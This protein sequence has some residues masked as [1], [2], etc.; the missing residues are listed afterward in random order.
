MKDII[1]LAKERADAF[2][3]RNVVVSTNSGTTAKMVLEVF[4]KRY[5]IIAVGNP[6]SAHERGLVRHKG[7]SEETRR[8]LELMGIRVVLQDQ[9]LF[10]AVSIGG[11][12]YYIGDIDITGP[13]PNCFKAGVSLEDIIK[14]AGPRGPYNPIAIIYNALQIFGDGP[15]VCLEVSLMAADSGV[16]PL[17]ADCISIQRRAGGESNMPDAALVL[18]PTKTQDI[19]NGQLR[20]KDLILVPGPKDHWFDNGPLWVG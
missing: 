1:A 17:D 10:Q 16:L 7:I 8:S 15:R 11:Q 2:G 5:T 19:F 6:E 20:V 12:P 13:S 3:I 9:S 4:G 18:R 14:D